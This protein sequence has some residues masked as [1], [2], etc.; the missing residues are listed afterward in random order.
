[1]GVE[2]LYCCVCDKVIPH[3]VTHLSVCV[4]RECFVPD[5]GCLDVDGVSEGVF[6]CHEE[7][8]PPSVEVDLSRFVNRN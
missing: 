2:H 1:M 4:Q 7:C 5:D 3:G 6:T 8:I